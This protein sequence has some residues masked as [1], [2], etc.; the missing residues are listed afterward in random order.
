MPTRRY[1]TFDELVESKRRNAKNTY[2]RRIA[3]DLENNNKKKMI[4]L[5]LQNRYLVDILY[6]SIEIN[7]VVDLNRSA[8]EPAAS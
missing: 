2:N 1:N 7:G 6:S 5:A 8:P 4:R 3:R